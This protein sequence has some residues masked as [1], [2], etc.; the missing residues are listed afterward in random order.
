MPL[1][2]AFI[3]VPMAE[4][5]V[6]IQVGSLIG[7]LWT[8]LV[9]ILTAAIGVALL[10]RQGMEVLTRASQRMNEGSLP[11]NE[12]AEGFMLAFAGALLLTPGF[13]TDA[14]GFSLLVPAVRKVLINSV[15][16]LL[17]P[18]VMMGGNFQGNTYDPADH[19]QSSA[20][21]FRQPF[22]RPG[23]GQSEPSSHRPE[24]IDGEFRRED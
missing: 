20:Q 22:K 8:I 6:L 11:A 17:K 15:L 10:K 1:L 12:L 19:H 3:I 2:L 23:T 16:K 14:L 4:L 24:V 9:I 18:K 7:T 21:P 13:L 5:A